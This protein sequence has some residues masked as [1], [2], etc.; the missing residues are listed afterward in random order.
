MLSSVHD[1]SYS[2]PGDDGLSLVSRTEEDREA[3][4]GRLGRSCASAL[5]CSSERS[6]RTGRLVVLLAS[7]GICFH[8]GRVQRPIPRR[9]GR[10]R[11]TEATRFERQSSSQVPFAKTSPEKQPSAAE[12]ASERALVRPAS[13]DGITTT[14]HSTPSPPPPQPATQHHPLPS[15]RALTPPPQRHPPRAPP[16]APRAL[17]PPPLHQ[18]QTPPHPPSQPL[19]P[20]HSPPPSASAAPS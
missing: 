18:P 20:P 3:E 6:A 4:D 7:W 13:C 9:R 14:R 8:S 5:K 11:S 16:S 12:D 10:H 17:L 1:R 15:R 2:D 19:P